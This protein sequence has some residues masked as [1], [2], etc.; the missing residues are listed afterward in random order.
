MGKAPPEL[1]VYELS[2]LLKLTPDEVRAMP[3]G[4]RNMLR[5]VNAAQELAR[6]HAMKE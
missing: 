3:L 2:L 1:D 5:M 6:A 4:D